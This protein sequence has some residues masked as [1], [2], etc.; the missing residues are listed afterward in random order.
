MPSRDWWLFLC[1]TH[2]D[3]NQQLFHDPIGRSCDLLHY[4]LV[5]FNLNSVYSLLGNF[6]DKHEKLGNND[7]QYFWIHIVHNRVQRLSVFERKIWIRDIPCLRRCRL[8]NW[9]YLEHSIA[10]NV[11]Q[12]FQRH[13][14]NIERTQEEI[15]ERQ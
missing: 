12:I 6:P 10:G 3:K 7:L 1:R 2:R 8:Y 5:R 4:F 11:V 14:G 13:S 15:K 9:H